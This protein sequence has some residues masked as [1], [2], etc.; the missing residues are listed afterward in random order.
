VSATLCNPVVQD[1]L[2]MKKFSIRRQLAR[3]KLG[4]HPTEQGRKGSYVAIAPCRRWVNLTGYF[5]VNPHPATVGTSRWAGFENRH[6]W[7][8]ATGGTSRGAGS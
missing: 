5:G 6:F 2:A 4:R 7:R 3:P 1:F 8:P